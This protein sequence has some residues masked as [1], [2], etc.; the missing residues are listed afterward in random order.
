MF[1]LFLCLLSRQKQVSYSNVF[2]ENSGALFEKLALKIL[3]RIQS[4]KQED[5]LGC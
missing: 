4:R 5:T 2:Q 1:D 3:A